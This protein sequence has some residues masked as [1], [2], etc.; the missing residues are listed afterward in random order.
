[1]T[2]VTALVL[3]TMALPALLARLVGGYPPSPGRNWR[4][5]APLAVA[6]AITAV[7]IAAYAAWWLAVLLAV[8][9]VLH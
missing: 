1:M 9:A 5:W 2:W 4:L 6:P 7:I 8:P 3:V